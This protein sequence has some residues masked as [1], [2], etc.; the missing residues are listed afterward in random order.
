MWIRFCFGPFKRLKPFSTV[1]S[2]YCISGMVGRFDKV[3]FKGFLNGVGVFKRVLS[4]PIYVDRPRFGYKGN[5]V[6]RSA[7]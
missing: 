2:V 4:I 7:R 5:K 6:S 1:E 3:G